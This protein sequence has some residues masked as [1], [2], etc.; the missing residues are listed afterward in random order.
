M[1]VA[2][3]HF[4]IIFLTFATRSLKPLNNPVLKA[5]AFFLVLAALASAF[6]FKVHQFDTGWA[7]PFLTGFF[8]VTSYASTTGFALSDNSAWPAIPSFMLILA[9]LVCGCA[10]S[11]TCGL[12][13]D[14]I[15]V[16][17]KA[18]RSQIYRALHP[19]SVSDVKLGKKVLHDEEVYPMILY[20]AMYMFI[21][22]ISAMLCVMFGDPNGTAVTGS[23][24]SMG[25]VGP[26]IGNTIGSMGNYNMEPSAIKF[27]FTC[28][29]FLGRVEIYPVLA[30]FMSIFRRK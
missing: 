18:M 3:I 9:S 6:S 7:D 17:V 4:G 28:D 11:T 8:H 24:A 12:K 23:I 19:S 22:A 20:V 25:N 5:Y 30:L 13:M 2:S 21:I 27:I 15:V 26:S 14:R 1:F 16:L 29:M 10:G